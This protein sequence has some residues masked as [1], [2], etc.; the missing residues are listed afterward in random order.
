MSSDRIKYR[1]SSRARFSIPAFG[2]LLLGIIIAACSNECYD[3]RN[4]LPNA[5][6]VIIEEG[7]EQ[8][9][10]LD[11]VIVYGIGAPGDSILWEGASMTSLY[12]PFRIDSDTTKYV[13]NPARTAVYDTVTFIY[14]RIPRFVSAECGVSYIFKMKDIVNSGVLIDSVVCPLGEI[15]NIASEN[16]IFY[17]RNE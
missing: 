1:I 9:V 7:N 8:E 13:F 12:L 5:K 3:N 15:T 14:S 11:S 6:F 4:A 2:V 10:R 17:M 16:I